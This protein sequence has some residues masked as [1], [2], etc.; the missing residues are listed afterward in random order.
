MLSARFGNLAIQPAVMYAQKGTSYK[1]TNSGVTIESTTRY[2][3]I[4]VPVNLVYTTGGDKGF[5]VFA[6]PYIGFGIGG[7]AK[8]EISGTGIIDGKSESDIKFDGKESADVNDTKIHAKNP[9]F[10][11]NAGIG[12]LVSGIQIQLGYGLGLSNLAPNDS[13]DKETDYSVKNK[14]LQ[15]SFSYLFNAN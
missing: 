6:G 8:L 1:S 14:Q 11:I 15:L 10:G 7:K 5:Q 12:Y 4:E 3:Y 2:E 13:D 9:D